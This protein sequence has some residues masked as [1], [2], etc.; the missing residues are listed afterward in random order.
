MYK[1]REVQAVEKAKAENVPIRVTLPDGTTREG[2]KGATTPQEI[3][4]TLSRSLAKKA[5]AAKVDG[6]VWDIFR[7]L[8]RDCQLQ[9]LTFDDPDGKETFWHSSAHVLGE[10]LESCFGAKLTI[11]PALEEG[12]YYDCYLGDRTLTEADRP[13]LE[14]RIE[15]IVKEKQEFD[16]VEVSREE[17]LSM[18]SENPFK[19][20]IIRGLPED[21][22]ISLY[23]CGPMVDLCHGPHLPNT[24]LLRAS[25]VSAMNRA[26]WRAD[27]NREPLQRVYGIT[28]PDAAS[29][30][31]YQ[32]RMEE[33]KKRDHRNIGTQQE[34]F[35]FD[36]LSPGSCFFQPNGARIY[37]ALV[38][39]IREKYWEYEYE[40]VVTPNL[41]NFELWERS[42]HADHYKDNMFLVDIE[43]QQFGLKPMNCPGHCLMFGHRLRSYREL[44]IR[45]ADFG[46][47][48]RNEYSGA[49]QGLTRVRRF[50]QDD[51]HVFCRPDQVMEEVSSCLR[52]L[53]EVYAVFGLTYK[54]ALSTR[55]DSYLGTLEQWDAAEAALKQALDATGKGWELNEADGA[56]YGP[57]ID[58]TVF[59]AL[60]RKFQCATIQL[61]FQLPVRFDLQYKGANEAFERP[62]IVHRAI[63]GSVERMLAILTENFAGKWPLWLSPRQVIVVPI[64]EASVAY[65]RR[66]RAQLRA[67]KLHVEVD[68]SDR[69]M[70]KKVREAQLAQFN[71]ILVVG[72]KE[73]AEGTVNVRTRDNVVHGMHSLDA[74]CLY[75][76][77]MIGS[78]QRCSALLAR[79]LAARTATQTLFAPGLASALAPLACACNISILTVAPAQ[80]STVP[81]HSFHTSIRSWQ[82]ASLN[83]QPHHEHMRVHKEAGAASDKTYQEGYIAPHPGSDTE[84]NKH[85]D[86]YLLMHPVYD[87]EY[88]ESIYPRHKTPAKWSE[89]TGFWAVT[90]MRW[91]F[92]K[93]TGYGPNMNEGKWLQRI[94][95]LETVAGVPGMV[96]GML[97]HMRSLRV[98][99]R[100]HGWIHTLLEEAENERMHLLTFLQLRKPGPLVRAGV[101]LTQGVFFNLYFFFYL[102][103][104]KHCH[105]FIGYLEEE[106]VKTYTHAISDIDKGRLPEWADKSAPDLAKFYWKMPKDATMRDL[107]LNVRADEACHS[108]VNHT[109]SELKQSDDNPFV[110]GN[111]EIA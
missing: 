43:E 84:A 5:L 20:E 105:A 9:I 58:I 62:V 76:E 44:P 42:G 48:H 53:D 10:A 30:K 73:E 61:D 67:A 11:G 82:Q 56:F 91:S 12:F 95:F 104:P 33:A 110:K 21:A 83:E 94:V 23:R 98:M 8:E 88:L 31:D 27:V 107:L 71:Y 77:P 47:L 38:E 103:S 25:A 45:M 28:F 79:Q 54:A 19:E 36:R 66:V 52:M 70:Q 32:H 111:H 86:S 41:Y 2:V 50:Q 4:S 109:F 100:D 22:T 93:I 64:S 65:A 7:P 37:N 74:W 6:E 16:R 55:P 49:L 17:A 85:G 108:H 26:F 102:L 72:E 96:G 51:A 81:L 75:E 78:M 14:K 57:K 34:L 18:F 80:L 101:L 39:L 69:K 106:A 24:G 68:D 89:K 15:Q 99:E 87:K 40:E 60:R 97:R 90:A 1:N 59:D 13:V 3:V 92:D 46:V 35:F 29:M 63:L